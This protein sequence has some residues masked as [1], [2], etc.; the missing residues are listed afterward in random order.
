MPAKPK[1]D[2]SS[3]P[4]VETSISPDLNLELRDEIALFALAMEFRMR[5][6]DQYYGDSWSRETRQ[7]VFSGLDRNIADLKRAIM[8]QDWREQANESCDVANWARF[9]PFQNEFVLREY[10]EMARAIADPDYTYPEHK[11]T[12]S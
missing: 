6:H 8:D 5:L 7:S 2:T 10:R 3:N 4:S 1:N 9:L 11:K 12:T